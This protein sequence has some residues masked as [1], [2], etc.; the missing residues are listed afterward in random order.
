[1]I[2]S[3]D[4]A[5]KN[6]GRM[7]ILSPASERTRYVFNRLIVRLPTDPF[8]TQARAVSNPVRRVVV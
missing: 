2:D 4:S 3:G 5:P 7:H 8:W 1:M 6:A